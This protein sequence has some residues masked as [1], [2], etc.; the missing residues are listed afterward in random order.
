MRF[1]DED[2]SDIRSQ[3]FIVNRLAA[4][5]R[6]LPAIRRSLDGLS[7]AEELVVLVVAAVAAADLREIRDELDTLDPLDL[8]EPELDLVP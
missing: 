2:G 5:P 4:P 8:L 3:R 1:S 6:P 7:V